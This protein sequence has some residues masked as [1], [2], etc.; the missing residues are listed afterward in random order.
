MPKRKCWNHWPK[1]KLLQRS[2]LVLSNG[3]APIILSVKFSQIRSLFWIG[4]SWRVLSEIAL[5]SNGRFAEAIARIQGRL[6]IWLFQAEKL[7]NQ[8]IHRQYRSQQRDRKHLQ[9]FSSVFFKLISR[10]QR[11]GENERISKFKNLKN[12]YLLFHGSNTA[13]FMGTRPKFRWNSRHSLPG[14]KNRTHRGRS[15]R[16]LP[17]KG[18]IFRENLRMFWKFSENF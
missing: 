6:S 8:R 2:S 14:A 9:V 15:Q 17:G 3:I 12:H 4:W 1:W 10:L 18:Q 11:K 16:I 7:G 13:N 5:H